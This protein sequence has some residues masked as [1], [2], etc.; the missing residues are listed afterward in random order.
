M[1]TISLSSDSSQIHDRLTKLQKLTGELG[2]S[3]LVVGTNREYMRK[4]QLGLGGFPE[5]QFLGV[6]A[7]DEKE[8]IRILDEA[9]ANPRTQSADSVYRNIGEYMLLVTDDRFERETGPDGIPWTPNTPFTLRQKRAAGKILKVL[10]STGQ[11][12]ASIQYQ[13]RR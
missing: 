11:A 4:H 9:I 10:Q 1:V 13:V 12:R 6:N 2:R 3:R 5:R 8:I 7:N